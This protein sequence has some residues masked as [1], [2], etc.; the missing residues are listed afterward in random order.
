MQ[1]NILLNRIIHTWHTC[2]FFVNIHTNESF[3]LVA[4]ITCNWSIFHIQ[5][6]F[7]ISNMNIFKSFKYIDLHYLNFSGVYFIL[8]KVRKL[9]F[10]LI[11]YIK[12]KISFV[13]II[14]ESENTCTSIN[15]LGIEE[16]MKYYLP[17]D[18]PICMIACLIP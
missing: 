12:N 18:L 17:L 7:C 6:L 5:Y 3:V 1:R 4:Y 11:W 8:V 14:H 9:K 2:T 15:V 13:E 16:N 10:N